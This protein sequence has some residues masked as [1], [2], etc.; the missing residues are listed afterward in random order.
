[1]LTSTGPSV[2]PFLAR[3]LPL[4]LRLLGTPRDKAR[5]GLVAGGGI[6][7]GGDAAQQPSPRALRAFIL[8]ELP[9]LVGAMGAHVRPWGAQLA[10]LVGRFA[11]DPSATPH[12]LHLVEQLALALGDGLGAHV[13]VLLPHVLRACRGGSAFLGGR[14]GGGG[15]GSGGDGGEAGGEAGDGEASGGG[16]GAGGAPTDSDILLFDFLPPDSGFGDAGPG[17]FDLAVSVDG[18]ARGA[19][20]VL[21][22]LRVLVALAPSLPP[23]TFAPIAVDELLAVVERAHALGV[24]EGAPLRAIARVGTASG[25]RERAASVVHRLSAF[26]R[27]QPPMP[28][29]APA[30]G[31]GGRARRGVTS[32]DVTPCS[33]SAAAVAAAMAAA[34][35]AA[36]SGGGVLWAGETF[37]VF[38]VL[39]CELG[40]EWAVFAPATAALAAELGVRHPAFER[41]SQLACAQPENAN[42]LSEQLPMIDRLVRRADLRAAVEPGKL[43]H[44][45]S[46]FSLAELGDVSPL[47]SDANGAPSAEEHSFIDAAGLEALAS[48]AAGLSEPFGSVDG[49]SLSR[50]GSSVTQLGGGGGGGVDGLSRPLAVDVAQLLKLCAA[51]NRSTADDWL[52]WTRRVS[53]G[54]LRESPCLGLRACA[55][56]AQVHAPLAGALFGAAFLAVWCELPDEAHAALAGSLHAALTASAMPLECLQLL[57]NLAEFMEA[58]EVIYFV[59]HSLL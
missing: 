30:T 40:A 22:A 11:D 14:V 18:G 33:G 2:A 23:A 21:L 50:M 46:L 8:R 45:S 26:L 52:E 6:G 13:G 10:A 49:L 9:P 42:A 20:V 35:A 47:G 19:P 5:G 4:L 15:G 59:D 38:C 43:A 12:C 27:R 25:L 51:E 34:A 57:L 36:T 31:W 55:T 16:D 56:L 54:L 1:M 44:A 29:Q 41:L 58:H 3:V 17:A 53:V 37:D 24:P 39:A 32:G 48:V 7:G 28:P